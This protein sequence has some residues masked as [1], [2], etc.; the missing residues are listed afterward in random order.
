MIFAFS[1]AFL[2]SLSHVRFRASHSSRPSRFLPFYF[3]IDRR[4]REVGKEEVEE[5]EEEEEEEGKEK[6]RESNFVAR[7]LVRRMEK[8]RG[9]GRL[10][11]VNGKMAGQIA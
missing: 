1:V 4:L 11:Y 3:P 5:G 9:T 6:G 8:N 2:F 10:S 7:K